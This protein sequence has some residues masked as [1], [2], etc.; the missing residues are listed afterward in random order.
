MSE[1]FQFGH[2]LS[3]TLSPA[4]IIICIAVGVAYWQPALR[5]ALDRARVKSGWLAL[6]IFLSWGASKVPD[7]SFWTLFWHQDYL[8]PQVDEL[9]LRSGPSFNA[10]FRQSL[11]ILAGYCHLKAIEEPLGFRRWWQAA[12]I[13]SAGYGLFLLLAAMA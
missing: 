10:V 3:L 1:F 6:G 4:T 7:N 2:W 12:F 13:I 11:S 5:A 9:L 8:R